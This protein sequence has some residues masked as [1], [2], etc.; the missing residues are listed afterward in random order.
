[1][2]RS[3]VNL[4][5]ILREATGVPQEDILSLNRMPLDGLNETWR[6]VL[7]GWRSEAFLKLQ[8]VSVP[9]NT[10]AEE[11][12]VLAVL[13]GQHRLVPELVARGS[14]V[15]TG[16]AYILVRGLRGSSLHGA[17]EHNPRLDC[18]GIFNDLLDWLCELQEHAGLRSLLCRRA[19]TATGLWRPDF[20]PDEG[21][22][23]LHHYG[24]DQRFSW[25]QAHA[26]KIQNLSS[27]RRPPACDVLHGSLSAS[28]I[29]VC[30]SR[31]GRGFVTGVLDYEAAR[32]G[33]LMFDVATLAL[34]LLM[35][36]GEDAAISWFSVC[37]S[38]FGEDR[39]V[40][41][42]VKFF[43]FLCLLRASATRGADGVQMPSREKVR[44]FLRQFRACE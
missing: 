23:E 35:E 29:L 36:A 7:R 27:I 13:S 33:N 15:E 5:K 9:S 6:C 8:G 30:S 26:T 20:S 34:H 1:M 3:G 17:I 28:N 38:R 25:L 11:G 42:G 37:A 43:Y 32:I 12:E 16:R 19:V 24:L 14:D 18:R 44:L 31:E 2:R 39:T 21:I 4:E 10:V 40:A 41:E 22:A